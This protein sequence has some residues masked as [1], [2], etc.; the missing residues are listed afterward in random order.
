MATMQ[1][2]YR[3]A[4]GRKLPD[5]LFARIRS[6]ATNCAEMPLA[7]ID[8]LR[9]GRTP[10][11]VPR[12]VKLQ[13]YLE[14]APNRT[15]RVKLSS[16]KDALGMPKIQMDWHMT[17]LELKT[18]GVMT[19]TVRSEFARLGLGTWR[20]HAWLDDRGEGWQEHL[21]D[22]SHHM[23]TTRMAESRLTGVVDPQCAVFG[24]KG[25]YIAGSSVFPT[26]GYANPTLTIVALALR[27][28]DHLKEKLAIA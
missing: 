27:L 8:W 10:V 26:S 3:A 15:S 28:A 23:G 9:T 7:L 11:S 5:K 17:D 22:C 20:P 19:E 12:A 2:F 4:R 25:L 24:V 18:V 14:Q 16:Q 1:A 21:S 6:L 13:C